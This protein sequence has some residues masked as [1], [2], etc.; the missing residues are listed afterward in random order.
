MQCAF[1][2]Y[3]KKKL[4]VTA[5]LSKNHWIVVAILL[6]QQKVYYLDSFKSLKTDITLLSLIINEYVISFLTYGH[7]STN[8][9]EYIN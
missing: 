9:A 5:Y 6:K 1:K 4:I 3:A 2:L 7:S 8:F